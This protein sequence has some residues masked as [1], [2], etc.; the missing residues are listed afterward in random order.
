MYLLL[1]LR[2]FK[3][4]CDHPELCEI[5]WDLSAIPILVPSKRISTCC[6]FS[7]C[8]PKLPT[9]KYRTVCGIGG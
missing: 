9:V 2:H 7:Y 3:D 1:S 8:N 4:L 6:A 5:P